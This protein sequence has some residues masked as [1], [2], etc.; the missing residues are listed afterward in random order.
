MGTAFVAR[1]AQVIA[2]IDDADTDLILLKFAGET[3]RDEDA[4]ASAER[5]QQPKDLVYRIPEGVIEA[6]R[7]EAEGEAD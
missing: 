5:L 3:F 4:L 6:L 2:L 7:D 1:Q